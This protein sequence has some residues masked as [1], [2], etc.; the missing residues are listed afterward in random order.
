MNEV[1]DLRELLRNVVA[2]GDFGMTL[3][4]GE[5]AVV[6]TTVGPKRLGEMLPTHDEIIASSG[7]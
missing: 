1:H 3:R 4:T 6:H 7:T 2:G 5:P